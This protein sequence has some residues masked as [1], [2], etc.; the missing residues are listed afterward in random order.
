MERV[1]RL[2]RVALLCCHFV[3]NYAYYKGA[4]VT[5]APTEKND[6]WATIKNNFLDIAVLEWTK[7]FGTYDEEHHWKNIVSD[8]SSFRKQLLENCQI[9]SDEFSSCRDKIKKYRDGFVAHLDSDEK[10]NIPVFDTA[11]K[12]TKYYYNHV[13]A[14]L[15]TSIM[16][17]PDNIE[18]YY[19]ARYAESKRYFQLANKEN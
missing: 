10:M 18:F 6:I 1:K 2:C 12:L 14:E 17:L 13:L 9:T 19:Q 5:K 15:K 8:S 4:W 11:L 16:N 3:R 7:L